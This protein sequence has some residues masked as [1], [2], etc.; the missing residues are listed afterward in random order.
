MPN[1][2]TDA[3]RESLVVTLMADEEAIQLKRERLAAETYEYFWYIQRYRQRSNAKKL[4]S[5]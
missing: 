2:G 3:D 1:S 4:I 5:A